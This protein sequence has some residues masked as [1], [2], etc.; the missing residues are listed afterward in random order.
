MRRSARAYNFLQSHH[1]AE[2]HWFLESVATDPDAQGKGVATA[3]LAPITERCDREGTVA[4]LET[5]N[6]RNVSFYE[7][8]GF[9]VTG[10]VD[11]PGGGPRIWLMK[12]APA[13]DACFRDKT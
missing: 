13:G 5:Q 9:V 7:H 2:P 6:S 4:Y 8:R 10:E 1:P 11:I 12:R 3:L